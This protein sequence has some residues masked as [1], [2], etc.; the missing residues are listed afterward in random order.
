MPSA[1]TDARDVGAYVARIVTDPRTLNQKVF[2]YTDLRT[3]HE[4]YDTVEKLSGEKLNRRYVSSHHLN[5]RLPLSEFGLLVS[6]E[7]ETDS[8]Q[9]QR[10]AEEIETGI[11]ATKDEPLK[12]MDYYQ[13]TYQK[14][15]D[16]MGEN[17]P[18]YARHLGYLIGKDLYPDMKGIAFEDFFNETLETGLKPMYE[19]HADWLRATS[20]FVFSGEGS[21]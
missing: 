14:S 11:A 1:R 19:E 21:A 16:I 2:A 7:L 8:S 17:T 10:T 13:Y 5:Y 20:S 18:E 12:I 3:E 6:H 15:Y 9:L 4:L